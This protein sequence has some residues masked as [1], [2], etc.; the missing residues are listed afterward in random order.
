MMEGNPLTL[1]DRWGR[2]A[3]GLAKDT[4]SGRSRE[5]RNPWKTKEEY[6]IIDRCYNS[7]KS[8]QNDSTGS[9]SR[10]IRVEESGSTIQFEALEGCTA[11]DE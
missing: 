5:E 8:M 1:Q 3:V 9:T 11:A 10:Y 6:H 7:K 2:L 4:S